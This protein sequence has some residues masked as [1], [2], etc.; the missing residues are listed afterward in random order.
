MTIL[1]SPTSAACKPLQSSAAG[2]VGNNYQWDPWMN[3]YVPVPGTGL[4]SSEA[5]LQ[6]TITQAENGYIININGKQHIAS[7]AEDI[8]AIVTQALVSAK[9]TNC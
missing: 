4:S 8:N 7:T 1:L 9:L 3:Q 5:M 2:G 6:F